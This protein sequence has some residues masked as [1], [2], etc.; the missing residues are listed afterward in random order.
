[1]E[2][3]LGVL[4]FGFSGGEE[5]P[6]GESEKRAAFP[7]GRQPPT[8]WAGVVMSPRKSPRCVLEECPRFCASELNGGE[9]RIEGAPEK[10]AAFPVAR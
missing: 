10:R 3:C 8:E 1:M 2:E 6:D 4:T 9:V 5:L 7:V